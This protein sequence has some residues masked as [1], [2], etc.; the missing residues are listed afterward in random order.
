MFAKNNQ[1]V[2]AI[3]AAATLFAIS[4][5]LLVTSLPSAEAKYTGMTRDFYIFS[6]VDENIDEDALG[7]PPDQFSQ[8]QIT[9]RKGDTV[10]IHFYNLEPVETQEHHSFTIQNAPYE[11]NY[12]LNAGEDVVIEFEATQRGIWEY[13]CT[14]HE[15][16][17][18]GQLV[19]WP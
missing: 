8:T 7:I 19:V 18:K 16:T 12:D 1:L 17:M 4:S 13:I 15:P 2:Y 5:T 9:V 10:R 14:Y 6:I 3:V 11:M